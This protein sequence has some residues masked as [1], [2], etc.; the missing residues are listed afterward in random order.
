M[1]KELK[2]L[3]EKEY[4]QISA[5]AGRAISII[6]RST[7]TKIDHVDLQMDLEFCHQHTPLDFLKMLDADDFDLVHD[8]LGIR[9]HL[10]R[11][12]G[13]LENCFVPRMAITEQVA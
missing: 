6:E 9:Q 13:E 2:K 7:G 8:V 11:E 5:I 10:N 1:A 4:R 3:T 12:T